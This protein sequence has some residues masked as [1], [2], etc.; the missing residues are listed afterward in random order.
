MSWNVP[1]VTLRFP[2]NMPGGPGHNWAN[3][4]AMATPIAH[5]GIVAGSKVMAMTMIDL[6]LRPELIQGAKA[7]LT[8]VQLKNHK[9]LPLLSVAIAS[10]L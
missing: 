6:L 2:A 8:D 10:P 3:G 9:V 7:Y 1:T 4:I 5:K